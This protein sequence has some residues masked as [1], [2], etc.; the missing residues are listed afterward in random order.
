MT[1]IAHTPAYT[2]KCKPCFLCGMFG[3][4]S[5]S[6]TDHNISRKDR[7]TVLDAW[8]A[9]GA[10]ESCLEWGYRGIRSNTYFLTSREIDALLDHLDQLGA[11]V[12]PHLR[13]R[14]EQLT[15][16]IAQ[17]PIF[18]LCRVLFLTLRATRA[19]CRSWAGPPSNLGVAVSANA[20][21]FESERH[22]ACLSVNT[23]TA[24]P[25]HVPLC[26]RTLRGAALSS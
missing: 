1:E 11:T 4:R 24:E 3:A 22:R 6:S 15:F 21:T 23:S 26:A 18:C 19:P 8:G 20:S 5:S 17:A 12:Q 2:E 14:S 25:S 16:Y 9:C 10:H 7:I 13:R